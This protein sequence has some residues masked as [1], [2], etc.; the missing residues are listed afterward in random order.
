MSPAT[1]ACLEL[2]A[3]RE[4]PGTLDSLATLVT[5]AFP[6]TQDSPGTVVRVV[7][8]ARVATRDSLPPRGTVDFLAILVLAVLQGIQDLVQ[9][10]D[11]AGT[12]Q[13]QATAGSVV[14]QV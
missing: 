8:A 3:T 2:Q 7:I 10:Q 12:H 14:T 11:T 4:S 5:L 6:A 13:P 1:P 9:I